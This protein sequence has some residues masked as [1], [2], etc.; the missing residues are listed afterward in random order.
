MTRTGSSEIATNRF[1]RPSPRAVQRLQGCAEGSGP[2]EDF[3][4]NFGPELLQD[5]HRNCESNLLCAVCQGVAGNRCGFGWF[6]RQHCGITLLPK[7]EVNSNP[8]NA[9]NTCEKPHEHALSE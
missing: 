2:V 3:V 6:L 5:I 9:P 8:T 4:H 1:R 7:Q